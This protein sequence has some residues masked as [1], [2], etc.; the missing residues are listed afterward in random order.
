MPDIFMVVHPL[1]TIVGKVDYKD[2]LV[3]YQ[4]CT[5]GSSSGIGIGIC[6][7]F[8]IVMKCNSC[9]SF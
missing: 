8:A 4:N 2:Y 9:L 3:V 5:I 7:V 1:V 6:F